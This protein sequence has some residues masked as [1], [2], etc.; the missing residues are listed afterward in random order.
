M[1]QCPACRISYVLNTIFCAE[2]GIYLPESDDLSTDPLET[3]EIRWAGEKDRSQATEAE[4]PDSE[5]MP[6]RLRIG[7]S[8]SPLL[9]RFLRQSALFKVA[10]RGKSRK[11]SSWGGHRAGGRATRRELEFRLAKPIRLGRIDPAQDIYPEVDL[12]VDQGFELGVSREHACMFRRGSA[13]EVE[14]L[15]STNGTLLNG[16][17][18]SPYLPVTLKDGDQLQL[19]MLLIQVGFGAKYSENP[20][21]GNLVAQALPA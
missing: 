15:A 16:E 10:G 6:I 14:D 5:W 13:I 9:R 18:L 19:G 7:Y 8:K 21:T 20:T 4:S 11:G 2:C 1:I 12:T 3:Q 17:R